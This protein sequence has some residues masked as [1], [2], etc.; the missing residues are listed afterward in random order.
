MEAASSL[1]A[2]ASPE[3]RPESS[4]V[5]LGHAMSA[6][7]WWAGKVHTMSLRGATLPAAGALLGG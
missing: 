2:A 1:P 4:P 7:Y 5:H 6:K 3:P